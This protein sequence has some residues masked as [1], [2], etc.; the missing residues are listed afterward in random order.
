[1]A[2]SCVIARPSAHVAAKARISKCG[3]YHGLM[4]AMLH[5][6]RRRKRK[7]ERI[8]HGVRL[9]EALC[10]PAIILEDRGD[11]REPLQ[12]LR[13]NPFVFRFLVQ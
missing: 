12:A 9:R 3:V 8:A 5:P 10:R 13:G 2:C 1:M 11:Q 4:L 6:L 7:A